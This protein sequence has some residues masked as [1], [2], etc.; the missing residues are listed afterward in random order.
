VGAA[1]TPLSPALR[2]TPDWIVHL[3]TLALGCATVY[4]AGQPI[5][6][7]DTWIHLALG[8]AFLREG[9]WLAADPHLFAAAGPP[10]PSSWLGSLALYGTWLAT[11]FTGLRIAH[12]LAVALILALAFRLARGAGA[13]RAGASGVVAGFVVLSTYRLVQLRPELFTIA[14]TLAL[15]PLLIAQ[16]EGPAPARVVAAALI[17]ALWANVHAAFVLGPVLV[18]GAALAV[19]VGALGPAA[20]GVRAAERRRAGRLAIAGLAMLVASVANPQGLDAHLAYFQ[21]GRETLELTAVIDEWGPTNLLAWPR[22]GLP[23]SLAAWLVCWLGLIGTL[24]AAVVFARERTS[25]S[26]KVDFR[27][28]PALLALAAAGIAAALVASRFLWLGVFALATSATLATRPSEHAPAV[29][30]RPSRLATAAVVAFTLAAA[31][32]HAQAGDW[33]MVTAVLRA[34]GA[35]YG[36]PYPTQRYNAHAV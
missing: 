15:H 33:R 28:D 32:L 1:I 26:G 7:N 12:A 24:G 21:A 17:A 16:R 29:A 10:S 22:P 2:P 14:A 23:P 20:V 36:A 11:G 30:R 4:A 6:A 13:S 3:V 27:I 5:Y 31:I 8:E 25:R 9:P 19:F 34:E 35:G 18:S